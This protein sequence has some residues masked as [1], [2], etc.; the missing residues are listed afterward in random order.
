[1]KSSDLAVL[2]VFCVEESSNLFGQ[3]NFWAKTQ[4]PNFPK[5]WRFSQK[6]VFIRIFIFTG[7]KK[8]IYQSSRFCQVPYL[9]VAYLPSLFF[10]KM[11]RVT[12]VNLG[13]RNM[14]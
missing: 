14:Q 6:R 2:E 7:I 9:G 10:E 12:F 13:L 5:T 4:G 11:G 8:H 1:M 3:D